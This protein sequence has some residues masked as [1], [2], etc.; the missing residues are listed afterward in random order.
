MRLELVDSFSYVPAFAGILITNVLIH[1]DVFFV[2][3]RLF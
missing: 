1:F 2:R 3:S